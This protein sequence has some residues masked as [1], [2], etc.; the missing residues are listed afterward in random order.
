MT[1]CSAVEPQVSL[2]MSPK[3][4]PILLQMQLS[5][6]PTNEHGK[7]S[8]YAVDT[9]LYDELKWSVVPLPQTCESSNIEFQSPMAFGS[10]FEFEMPAEDGRYR[11]CVIGKNKLTLAWQGASTASESM[12]FEVDRS[13]PSLDFSFK[14]NQYFTNNSEISLMVHQIGASELAVYSDS[15]CSQTSFWRPVS[16][17]ISIP[18]LYHNAENTI[19]LK[20]RDLAGNESHCVTKNIIHDD[21]AP[22]VSSLLKSAAVG[23]RASIF[24]WEIRSSGGSSYSEIQPIMSGDTLGCQLKLIKEQDDVHRVELTGCAAN[25]GSVN[26]QIP[27]GFVV[28]EAT[29][30]SEAVVLSSAILDNEGPK[31]ISESV[32]PQTGNKDKEF[33]W[34]IN[35]NE[36]PLGTFSL[37]DFIVTGDN[38]GCSIANID[39]SNQ[40]TPRVKVVGCTGDGSLGLR[41]RGNSVGDS[42][43]NPLVLSDLSSSVVVDNTAPTGTIAGP[44]PA[45]GNSSSEFLWTITTTETITELDINKINLTTT[46][47][48]SCSPPSTKTLGLNTFQIGLKNCLSDGTVAIHLSAGAAKDLA[49]NALLESAASASAQVKNSGP[50]LTISNPTP[51]LGMSSATFE[52]MIDYTSVED[53]EISLAA[54]DIT[55][56]GVGAVGCKVLVA[57][58]GVPFRRLV[59]VSNCAG[60]GEIYIDIAAGTARDSLGNS[61]VAISGVNRK[62]IVDNALPVATLSSGKFGGITSYTNQEYHTVNID[63]NYDITGLD[64]NSFSTVGGLIESIVPNNNKSYVAQFRATQQGP[65]EIYLKAD[66][67]ERLDTGAR[68]LQSHILQTNYDSVKPVIQGLVSDVNWKK[69]D[70]AS[71]LNWSCGDEECQYAVQLSSS[72]TPPSTFSYSSTKSYTIPATIDSGIHYLHVRGKDLAGNESSWSQAIIKVDKAAP[73]IDAGFQFTI[74]SL[75]TKTPPFDLFLSD[76]HSGMSSTTVTA[77][78]KDSNGAIIKTANVSSGSKQEIAGSFVNGKT[79]SINF[80][81][82]D[83]VGNLATETIYWQVDTEPITASIVMMEGRS[84]PTETPLFRLTSNKVVANYTYRV[85]SVTGTP[86]QE[87]TEVSLKK[88]D[89]LGANSP[90]KFIVLYTTLRLGDYYKLEV[91]IEYGGS[92]KKVISDPWIV[93]KCPEGYAFVAAGN[94]CLS[95]YEMAKEVNVPVSWPGRMPF[96]DLTRVDAILACRSLNSSGARSNYHLITNDQWQIVAKEILQI[97]D[98]WVSGYSSIK[99]GYVYGAI[100]APVLATRFQDSEGCVDDGILESCSSLSPQRE[101]TLKLASG[102]VLWDFSG[103]AWEW[104]ADDSLSLFPKLN[105]DIDPVSILDTFSFNPEFQKYSPLKSF[106][107]G[108]TFYDFEAVTPPPAGIG[109]IYGSHN[110][111]SPTAHRGI[112]R[113]GQRTDGQGGGIFS[114]NMHVDINTKN[115]AGFRC[116]YNP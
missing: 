32:S 76:I 116:V 20:A 6:N 111:Y 70:I 52:W 19:G 90:N 83:K 17:E 93:S 115:H 21:Q 45:T 110:E 79:Y 30:K 103:N 82:Q 105:T 29:N 12:A 44:F 24:A 57:S 91:D 75:T 113:G 74:Y 86:Y 15:E 108:S 55:V 65:L 3:N 92:T 87:I 34:T 54:N 9:G 84:T 48:V 61:T 2:L 81:A 107:I 66:S 60:E 88:S 62:A 96:M 37:S 26:V 63:F 7:M 39:Q 94:F 27:R 89:F 85:I 13:P 95:K 38:Q 35:I 47:G 56:R 18:L 1:A 42:L 102:E 43:G 68:A 59:S 46:G 5:K 36:V 25:S 73:V 100:G 50:N 71:T 51:S 41:Y 58:T 78:I 104:V 72:S 98:N 112:L 106:Y 49:G 80:S 101:R 99:S 14:N 11:V 4:H 16:S 77:V 10:P 64:V 33:I 40:Q 31:V 8:V 53:S 114:V 109:L 69:Y 67:V 23:N 28:D 97:P 22:V